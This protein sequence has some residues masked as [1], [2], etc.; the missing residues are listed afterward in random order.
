MH[1]SREFID[2]LAA[3]GV[4]NFTTKEYR[5]SLG[6]SN[7]ATAHS[8]IRLRKQK[9]I[10]TPIEGFHLI[11][12]PTD[13]IAGCLQADQFIDYLMRYQGENYYVGLLSAAEIHGAAHHR[14]QVFQVVVERNRKQIQC[15]RERIEFIAKKNINTVPTIQHKVRTGYVKVSSSEMTAFDLVGYDRRAG[16]LDNVATVLYELSENLSSAKLQDVAS[17]V[18]ITWVQRLGF[19]F[20][21]LGRKKLASVL[22]NI[23]EKRAT[24]VTPLLPGKSFTGSERSK[25]WKVAINER[26]EPDI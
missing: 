24:R 5:A 23:V 9:L 12:S 22:K 1:K 26:I 18:D 19:L 14:P 21:M 13:R 7:I 10:A 25:K 8:L 20:E 17:L 4:I 3:K 6:I 11:L 2:R 16:G 15:G